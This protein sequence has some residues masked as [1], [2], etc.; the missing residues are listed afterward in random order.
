MR[1][2]NRRALGFLLTM[3][4]TSL[5]ASPSPPNGCKLSEFRCE[6]RKCVPLTRF[7]NNANDCGDSSDEP[8]YCT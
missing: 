6:N 4:T 8:R 1:D 2:S 7:C 5:A 3:L